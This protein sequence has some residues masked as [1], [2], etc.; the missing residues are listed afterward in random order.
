MNYYRNRGI[1]N[2][3][4]DLDHL[5]QNLTVSIIIHNGFYNGFYKVATVSTWFLQRLS[6]SHSSY[7]VAARNRQSG[8]G[9]QNKKLNF[10]VFCNDF[11]RSAG[12]R[13]SSIHACKPWPRRSI[14]NTSRR[15]LKYAV[16]QIC[17]DT[18]HRNKCSIKAIN[19]PRNLTSH[20]FAETHA[21]PLPPK[22]NV[23]SDP[24]SVDDVFF[25]MIRLLTQLCIRGGGDMLRGTQ[26]P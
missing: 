13:E 17:H 2:W 4:S 6:S 18:G 11:F 5:Q 21:R 19:S 24:C 25:F 3:S 10:S 26:E 14:T 9:Q 7:T 1:L 16:I 20:C 22:S 8:N 12:M 15:Q 23:D